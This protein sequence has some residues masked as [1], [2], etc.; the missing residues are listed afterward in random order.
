M[1]LYTFKCAAGHTTPETLCKSDL[2][3]APKLCTVLVGGQEPFSLRICG[4]PLERNLE[5]PASKFPGADSW[6]GGV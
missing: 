5:A 6:R 2:S 4:K 3:D 1:P